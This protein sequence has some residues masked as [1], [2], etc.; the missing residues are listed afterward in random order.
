MRADDSANYHT[1]ILNGFTY[2][3]V[4]NY[5]KEIWCNLEGRYMHI[6][7]DLN[8]LAGQGYSM[9]LCSVGVMG[10][11]YVRDETLPETLEIQ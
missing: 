3:D 2:S 8:H 1:W 10:T 4:W 5:G 9:E 7:S 6:I 11:K